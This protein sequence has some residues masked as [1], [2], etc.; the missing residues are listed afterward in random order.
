MVTTI[1]HS[2][3]NNRRWEHKG[4]HLISRSYM[5]APTRY[6]YVTAAH[7]FLFEVNAA[8]TQ[9]PESMIPCNEIH[10]FEIKE[11]TWHG[12]YSL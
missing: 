5:T 7:M 8:M 3:F 2:Q 4:N 6:I 1:K 11:V 10:N 12:I 9:I